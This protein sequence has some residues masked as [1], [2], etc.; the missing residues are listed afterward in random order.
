ML[1]ELHEK[2]SLFLETGEKSGYILAT[3]KVQSIHNFDNIMKNMISVLV[4]E[5]E[6]EGTEL[7]KLFAVA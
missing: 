5:I 6:T 3:H 7:K 4:D 2:F 1:D